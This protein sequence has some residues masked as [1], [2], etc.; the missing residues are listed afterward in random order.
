MPSMKTKS[1]CYTT[2]NLH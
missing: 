2:S 1:C